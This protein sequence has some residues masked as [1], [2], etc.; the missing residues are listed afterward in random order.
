MINSFIYFISNHFPEFVL[1]FLGAAM[2]MAA[3]KVPAL[4]KGLRRDTT[5]FERG[6]WE[7]R[8]ASL[9]NATSPEAN[10]KTLMVLFL[11]FI[12]VI[13]LLVIA[14]AKIAWH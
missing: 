10:M 1:V 11:G 5:E 2:V 7:G 8:T 13:F 6:L 3:I 14:A 12:S 9:D 4:I